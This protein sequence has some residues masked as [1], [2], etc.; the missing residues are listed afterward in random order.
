VNW[1][2]SIVEYLIHGTIGDRH[3]LEQENRIYYMEEGELRNKV[4]HEES[5]ICIAGDP[6][7]HLI[8]KVHEQNGYHLNPNDAI[9]QILNGPY[10]WPTIA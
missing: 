1:R 9:Q 10:W 7:K 4:D 3:P 6:I 8:K 2:T 5:K